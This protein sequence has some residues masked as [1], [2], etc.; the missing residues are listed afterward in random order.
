MVTGDTAP[1]R[2]QEARAVEAVLLH[3]PVPAGRL[4]AELKACL[5]EFN[6]LEQTWREGPEAATG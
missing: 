4:K 6:A 5:A 1:D 3:K 2:L